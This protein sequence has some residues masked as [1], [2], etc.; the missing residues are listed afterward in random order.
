ME[1]IKSHFRFNKQERSGIFFLLLIIFACQGLY[2]YVKAQPFNGNP[3]LE[4][5]TL[6]QSHLDSL[7]NNIE[8]DSF[9]L[10]PFNPNYI[11]D[12]KG[13]S[14]GMST[15][16]VDR[17][18][19]HRLANKFVNSAEE[20]QQVTKISD[21]LLGVIAPYFKFPNWVRENKKGQTSFKSP[22]KETAKVFLDL[23]SATAEQLQTVRG[24]G[25]TLSK[26]IIKFRDR[27]G[28]FLVNEQLYDV[29]GL[30]PEVI[31]RALEQFQVIDAPNV[32]KI[33]VNMATVEQ[34]AQLIYID[35]DLAREIVSYRETNGAFTTLNELKRLK[36][37][38]ADRIERIKLYLS[39]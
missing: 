29:Y 11:T 24:I 4:V 23:N 12:Y 27:L 39:L 7:K 16:E 2:F 34:L 17:L 10:F 3:K 38:P 37:F 36:S 25:E 1:E 21:S 14:L 33:N 32:E 26:R 9:E 19:A 18:L 20:F 28:G 31:K 15:E 35:Y 5:N 8:K 6:A 30:E 22:Q 13:Y